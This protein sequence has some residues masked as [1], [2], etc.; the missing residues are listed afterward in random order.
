MADQKRACLVYVSATEGQRASVRA[1]L[2]RNGYSV[3]EVKAEL[4]DALVAQ[5][6]QGELPAELTECISGADLCIFLLPESAVSDEALGDAAAFAQRLSKRM[7]GIVAG[8]RGEY[9]QSLDDH[10]SSMIREG[11]DRLDEAICGTEVWEQ[12]DRSPVLHRPIK[13]VRCQ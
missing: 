6:G 5:S 1:R 12:P 3:C 10:A 4:G 13:H 11:S 2:E 8:S 7:V 9:P